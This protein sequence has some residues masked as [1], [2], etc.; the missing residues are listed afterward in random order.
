MYRKSYI[1]RII[2]YVFFALGVLGCENPLPEQGTIIVLNQS[3]YVLIYYFDHKTEAVIV[4][5]GVYE[6]SEEVGFHTL[7]ASCMYQAAYWPPV[8]INLG[9]DGY[10]WPLGN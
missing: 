5:E 8:L 1:L 9:L 2:L 4:P 10:T 3:S 7:S 6:H